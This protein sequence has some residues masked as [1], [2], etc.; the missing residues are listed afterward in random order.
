MKYFHNVD[1]I[2]ELKKQ[3]K[4]LCKRYHPDAPP[5][6]DPAFFNESMKQINSENEELFMTCIIL[7]H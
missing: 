5:G 7:R 4:D 1:C 2:E 3:F 6:E